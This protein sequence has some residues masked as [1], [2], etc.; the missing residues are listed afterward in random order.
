[1]ES[2]AVP[3]D[4]NQVFHRRG[5]GDM[6]VLAADANLLNPQLIESFLALPIEINHLDCGKESERFGKLG[7]GSDSRFAAT[8]FREYRQSPAH[9]LLDGHNAH[10]DGLGR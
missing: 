6:K 2:A 1:V 5:C 4:N 8:S 9:R 7:I 10:G 3:G